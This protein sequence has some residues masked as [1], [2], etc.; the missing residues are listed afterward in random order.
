MLPLYIAAVAGV[1]WGMVVISVLLAIYYNMIIAYN[2]YYLFSSFTS[3]LPWQECSDDWVRD[4]NCT[5]RNSSDSPGGPGV[6]PTM[7]YWQ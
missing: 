1:G 4:Y 7:I 5:E 6:T 3:E 2:F